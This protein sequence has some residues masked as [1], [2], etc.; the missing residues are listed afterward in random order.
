MP[1]RGAAAERHRPHPAMQLDY[2]RG[3]CAVVDQS[4]RPRR[5][6]DQQARRQA[7]QFAA[8]PRR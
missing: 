8:R 6:E 5:A 7:E 3:G 1:P 4:E 2:Q